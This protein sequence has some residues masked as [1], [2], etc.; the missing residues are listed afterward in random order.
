MNSIVLRL[1]VIVTLCASC[2]G[3]HKPPSAVQTAKSDLAMIKTALSMYEIDYG[4]YHTT[5]QG[6]NAL[7]NAPVGAKSWHGPY[8]IGMIRFDPWGRKYVYRS[9]GTNGSAYDLLS[10]GADG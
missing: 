2:G 3:C 9:P 10:C 5:Q 7:V 6:L 1:M 8:L 4:S